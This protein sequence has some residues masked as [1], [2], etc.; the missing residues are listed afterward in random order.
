MR[1]VYGRPPSGLRPGV[2]ASVRSVAAALEVEQKFTRA[3]SVERWLRYR[4]DGLE[5]FP[6]GIL[7]F[8]R[9]LAS[10]A[11]AAVVGSERLV[12]ADYTEH[13]LS[14]LAYAQAAGLQVVAV[15]LAE[16][17]HSMQ[18]DSW[19]GVAGKRD[20][21]DAFS[22]AFDTGRI[23]WSGKL[24]LVAEFERQMTSYG[25]RRS[26]RGMVELEAASDE[27]EEDLCQAVALCVWYAELTEWPYQRQHVGY[28]EGFIQY[29]R[30]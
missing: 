29:G 2:I 6:G 28:A 14:S 10:V 30:G 11:G 4:V 7:E 22:T 24:E 23:R 18:E 8:Y 9:R 21:A 25:V 27:E 19:D 20:I 26:R 13:G 3:D 1:Y 5:R 15:R 12:F 17:S 16:G